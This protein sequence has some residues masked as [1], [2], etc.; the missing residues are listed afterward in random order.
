M[1]GIVG[2][3]GTTPRE[4]AVHKV[5][6]MLDA[7]SYE[8]FY[9]RGLYVNE[10]LGLYAGWLV[11]PKSFSDCMPVVSEDSNI[12][13]LFTENCSPLRI[14]WRVRGVRA[15]LFKMERKPPGGSLSGAWPGLFSQAERDILRNPVGLLL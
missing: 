4:E 5:K 2:L 14:N 7:M 1:P 12:A 11:H 8:P 13:L 15:P 6:L 9:S 10:M 3:I